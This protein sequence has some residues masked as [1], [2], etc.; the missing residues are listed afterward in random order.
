MGVMAMS[1]FSE[2]ITEIMTKRHITQKQ[3]AEMANVTESAMS[4]YVKGGRTPRID[5]LL[6]A[7]ALHIIEVDVVGHTHRHPLDKPRA[8]LER[9]VEASQETE[10]LG[11]KR[12]KTEHR[13]PLTINHDR[14]VEVEL[15]E[16]H[17]YA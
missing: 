9:D 11:C 12:H 5:V 1:K 7:H 13:A 17:R 4:Y 14:V 10:G 3:L 8:I 15:V 2:R 6:D 16:I